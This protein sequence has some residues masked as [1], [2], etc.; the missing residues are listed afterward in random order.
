MGV[1]SVIWLLNLWWIT[2]SVGLL[3]LGALGYVETLFSLKPSRIRALVLLIVFLALSLAQMLLASHKDRA[4]QAQIKADLTDA[5]SRYEQFT[6][7]FIVHPDGEP[8]MWSA[9]SYLSRH[10][11]GGR[12]QF[13]FWNTDYF[14]L[15]A[16]RKGIDYPPHM[17]IYGE[18]QLLLD[19]VQ[20]TVALWFYWGR[21]VQALNETTT[22]PI[23]ET[24]SRPVRELLREGF[25]HN[26]FFWHMT[27]RTDDYATNVYFQRYDRPRY[28]RVGE[29]GNQDSVTRCVHVEGKHFVI[30]VTIKYIESK[31]LTDIECKDLGLPLRYNNY[32]L[33]YLQAYDFHVST[34][35]R[36]SLTDAPLTPQDVAYPSHLVA[37]LR[38]DFDWSVL[39]DS[40]SFT[41]YKE[42]L[43][44]N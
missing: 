8:Y 44:D 22:T 14:A 40:L 1:L 36:Y 26:V 42:H 28:L 24:S 7:R 39:S 31:K 2:L 19:T 12:G 34:G 41:A 35:I 4:S 23:S 30:E 29:G 38:R 5:L 3:V 33:P 21:K 27:E 16:N 43:P 17:Q 15:G 13:L 32:D 11:T 6:T 9:I 37:A 10:Y 20:A 25:P 18:N